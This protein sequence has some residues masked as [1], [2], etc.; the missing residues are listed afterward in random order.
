MLVWRHTTLP[1]RSSAAVPMWPKWTYSLSRSTIGVAL[2]AEFFLWRV[3]AL[4]ASGWKTSEFQSNSPLAASRQS[5]R[6][7][8]VALSVALTAVVRYIRP[9]ANTGE[10]QPR[11][12]ISFRHSTLL[13]AFQA[14]GTFVADEFP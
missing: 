14:T 1:E 6:S 3:L 10:D 5:A 13:V 12:G 9:C 7:E 8:T 4:A 2:A 11:P